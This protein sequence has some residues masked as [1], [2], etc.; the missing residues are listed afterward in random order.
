[1]PLSPVITQKVLACSRKVASDTR[2]LRFALPVT[3]ISRPLDHAREPHEA[4]LTRFAR[5]EGS[6]L[7][8]G[9]NQG[10]C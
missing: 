6:I 5:C 2:N 8:L 10:S 4:Y 9:M 7:F 3:H 1:M